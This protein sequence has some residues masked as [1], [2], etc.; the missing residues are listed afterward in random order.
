MIDVLL[1]N[2]PGYRG[3]PR[4]GPYELASVAEALRRT[5]FQSELL[6]VQD[7]VGEGTVAFPDGFVGDIARIIESRPARVLLITLRTTA[8]PWALLIS[9]EYRKLFPDTVILAFAPRIEHRLQRFMRDDPSFD[10]LCVGDPVEVLPVVAQA[11]RTDGRGGLRRVPGLV[12]RDSGELA[13]S[14]EQPEAAAWPTNTEPWISPDRSIAAVHVG[15]GCPDRC[16]F[17]AAHLG[18]GARPRYQEPEA[19]A[20]DCALAFRRLGSPATGFVMLEAEN[21]T[22]NPAW[23]DAFAKAREKLG[24]AFPWG[25]YGRIDHMDYK[26]QRRLADAG[27][28]FLFIGIE[29]GSTGLQKVLG[30][31]FDLEAVLPRITALHAAGIATQSS[32]MYGI[33]G[34]TD[35]DF[36]QTARLIAEIA[37]AGGY[38]DWSPLRIEAGT[39]MERLTRHHAL[40]LMT[41]HELY[42]DLIEAGQDPRAVHP[43]I[44]YRMYRLDLPSLGPLASA[45]ALAWR[46]LLMRLPLTTYVLARG[47]DLPLFRQLRQEAP[48]SGVQP[49]RRWTE[50]VAGKEAPC[51]LPFVREL[52]AYEVGG[53]AVMTTQFNLELVYPD[54]RRN[55]RRIGALFDFAWWS[56]NGPAVMEAVDV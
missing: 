39:A 25:A 17:C 12:V 51:A 40:T 33:P 5:G 47:L 29:T 4:R 21:L 8:G 15:R 48:A 56:V 31:H 50:A 42:T 7:A 54:L 37:W 22:S 6:D 38:V 19:A 11:V 45:S 3:R 24:A 41:D 20:L 26:M 16:T 13:V 55:P 53:S 30:K 1:I 14:L 49:L 23:L 27:C 9:R 44:G 52:A 18:R 2:P 10:A 32:F 43:E 46:T 28:C 36:E 35:E 34:E